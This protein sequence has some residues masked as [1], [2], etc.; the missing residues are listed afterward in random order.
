MKQIWL[1]WLLLLAL[2]GCTSP[3]M[4][5]PTPA[6]PPQTQATVAPLPTLYPPNTAVSQP[7]Q[8]QPT[9]TPNTVAPTPPPFDFS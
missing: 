8:T 7:A 6:N 5:V 9:R 2:G 3:P 1:L 4:A